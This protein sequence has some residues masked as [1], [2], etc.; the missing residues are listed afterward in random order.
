MSKGERT[1]QTILRKALA[2]SSELG[3]EGLTI[4]VL[5]KQAGLSKSGLYAHFD[6]KEAL[7]CEVLG[8]AVQLFVTAVL[9]PALARPR[10]LPRLRHLFTR[11][12]E[13]SAAEFPGG[14][15]FVAA[16]SEYDDRPGPVRDAL[17]AH[18]EEMLAMLERAV[19]L[20]KEEGHLRPEVDPAQFAFHLWGILLAHHHYRRLLDDRI[21]DERASRAFDAMLRATEIA[22]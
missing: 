21:A 19:R 9:S 14:C 13:W 18:I 5:A 16:A 3:L 22:A 12:L 2:L 15:P 4:G 7:Q 17:V 6:S 1:R 11:W 20:A 8:A 10:G